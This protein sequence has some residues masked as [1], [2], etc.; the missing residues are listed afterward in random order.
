[1]P[2][3]ILGRPAK[4]LAAKK[5]EKNLVELYR[6]NNNLGYSEE[7]EHSITL[8][9][10]QEFHTASPSRKL[11]GE[12][13]R[14]ASEKEPIADTVSVPRGSTVRFQP[15]V[16]GTITKKSSVTA[17]LLQAGN[18]RPFVRSRFGTGQCEVPAEHIEPHRAQRRSFLIDE[19]PI[20]PSQKRQK[21]I[22]V[23]ID[24]LAKA[25]ATSENGEPSSNSIMERKAEKSFEEL[26]T[27]L[28]TAMTNSAKKEAQIKFLTSAMDTIFKE[29]KD[30][31]ATFQ[32]NKNR[33][34]RIS[35]E[36]QELQTRLNILS[37]EK[38]GLE[39]RLADALPMV[40]QAAENVD[41]IDRLEAST[42]SFNVPILSWT[43]IMYRKL[44][45]CV[46]ITFSKSKWLSARSLGKRRSTITRTQSTMMKAS[47][48]LKAL[49][50]ITLLKMTTWI[51]HVPTLTL[52]DLDPTPV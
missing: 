18:D 13:T 8:S 38:T 45:K 39:A 22:G 15:Q 48:N 32:S 28:R 47:D 20:I 19:G 43:D 17:K 16:E 35:S 2:E 9:E 50:L 41:R 21:L 5:A 23:V 30:L 36:K 29:N 49:L 3:G 11:T 42:H 24:P 34:D 25:P 27:L 14:L 37:E 26:M 12:R 46:M 44:L 6:D 40:A 1:M 10:I 31:S 7:V 33:I 52:V 51:C 4:R